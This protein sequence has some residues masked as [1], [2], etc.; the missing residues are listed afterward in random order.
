RW[1][2]STPGRTSSR[3]SPRGWPRTAS[4]APARSGARRSAT[5]S[6]R[7][8]CPPTPS[9]ATRTSSPAASAS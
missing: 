8:G 3:S 1:A 9:R 7:W 4:A 2:A 6:P 5:S